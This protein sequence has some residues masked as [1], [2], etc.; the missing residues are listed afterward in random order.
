M[1]AHMRGFMTSTGAL[2][3][4]WSVLMVM[5][6]AIVISVI[7]TGYT[8][9]AQQESNQ[10]WCALLILIDVPVPK[11]PPGTPPDVVARQKAAASELHRIRVEFGCK[12]G[13]V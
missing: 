4:R 12:R 5:V 9:V 2:R 3:A 7:N 1:K 11:P 6:T 10:K 13:K 8:R